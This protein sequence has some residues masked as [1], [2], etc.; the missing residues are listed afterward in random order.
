MQMYE[1]ILMNGELEQFPVSGDITVAEE[2]SGDN[3]PCHPKIMQWL[4]PETAP[5]NCTVPFK[6]GNK[7]VSVVAGAPT[8]WNF[9]LR[10]IKLTVTRTPYTYSCPIPI[11]G[12]K[13]VCP[14]NALEDLDQVILGRWVPV[15]GNLI[16]S[17][18]VPKTYT[19]PTGNR[20]IFNVLHD[21]PGGLS[22]ATWEEESSTS[23]RINIE[24]FE[25][26]N[27]AT[28]LFKTEGFGIDGEAMMEI[29]PFG[30]GLDTAISAMDYGYASSEAIGDPESERDITK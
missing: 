18:G 24:G 23:F 27:E 28:T 14:A 17:G 12:G 26:N 13:P 29:A 6:N 3:S 1:E 4:T 22:T 5:P 20:L 25:G 11:G 30:M 2:V 16:I 8:K 10:E 7:T 9:F 21:P 15:T 19:V